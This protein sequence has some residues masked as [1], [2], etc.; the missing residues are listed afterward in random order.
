[1]KNELSN[2]VPEISRK[3]ELRNELLPIIKVANEVGNIG[4]ASGFFAAMVASSK[5]PCDLVV[6]SGSASEGEL[7]FTSKC[8]QGNDIRYKFN[9]LNTDQ[10]INALDYFIEIGALE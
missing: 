9:C 3:E 10:S 8:E 4:M 7:V 5:M 6:F 2:K 1:M